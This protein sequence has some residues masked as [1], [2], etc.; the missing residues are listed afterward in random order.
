MFIDYRHPPHHPLHRPIQMTLH[1]ATINSTFIIIG[2]CDLLLVL[3]P[4]HLLHLCY[5][6][7]GDY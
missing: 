2:F 3:L 5:H 7:L 4:P 1:I 6:L